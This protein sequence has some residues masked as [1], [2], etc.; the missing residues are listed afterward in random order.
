MYLAHSS[1]RVILR[2]VVTGVPGAGGVAAIER[3]HARLGGALLSPRERG[4]WRTRQLEWMPAQTERGPRGYELHA[5]LHGI[6]AD[7]DDTDPCDVS[8]LRDI[9]GV[10]LLARATRVEGDIAAGRRLA[11]HLEAMGFGWATFPV[12]VALDGAGADPIALGALRARIASELELGPRPVLDASDDAHLEAAA[13]ALVERAR[14]FA[15]EG[16][17]RVIEEEVRASEEPPPDAALVVRSPLEMHL[18]ESLRPCACGSSDF[19]VHPSSRAEGALSVVT[20]ERRCRRCGRAQT[21]RFAIPEAALARGPDW[22]GGPDAS[23]ALDAGELIE[24]SE[25]CGV[26]AKG[27]SPAARRSLVLAIALLEDALRLSV[28]GVGIPHERFMSTAGRAH[29]RYAGPQGLQRLR[30]RLEAYRRRLPN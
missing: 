14:A 6:D 4:A 29:L 11:A 21:L 17:V 27:D 28:E 9:D 5:V 19:E 30:T 15:R 16:R 12:V 18:W 26:A 10:L 7:G 25:R 1:R 22:L 8:N 3:L 13:L 20:R 2:L 23:T 24:L